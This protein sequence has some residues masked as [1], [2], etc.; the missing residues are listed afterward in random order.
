MEVHVDL[1]I[2][3]IEIEYRGQDGAVL[4]TLTIECVPADPT[5]N[6]VFR[7]CVEAYL[8]PLSLAAYANRL[9]EETALPAL[10]KCYAEAVIVGC[11]S[12]EMRT[13]SRDEW[14][15][16]LVDHPTEFEG[17]RVRLEP[18]E[19]EAGGLVPRS[20]PAAG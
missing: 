1:P 4:R 17:L 20:Q 19:G 2:R 6:A 10:A 8:K 12:E 18:K 14:A 5:V 3:K 11:D 7:A 9:R 13:W 16:W 15:R